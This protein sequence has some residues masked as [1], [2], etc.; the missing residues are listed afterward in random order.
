MARQNGARN[1]E[2][3]AA[4]PSLPDGHYV[5]GLV[6][7]DEAIYADEM[8]H[9]H[10]K[11]WHLACHESELAKAHDFRTMQHAG[12]PLVV[13]RSED[14]QV[15]AF[16]NACSHRG[17]KIVQEPGG[18]AERLTCFYHMWSYDTFGRCIDIPRASGYDAVGLNKADC[19][20]REV[21]T[22]TRWGL[23]FVNLDDD[24]A[25]LDDFLG[26]SLE[27]FESVFDGRELEVFHFHRATVDANWKAWQ[28]TVLDIY[29]EF[30]HVVLR[31]TQMNATPMES[32]KL[33]T[34]P[35]GHGAVIGLKA[36][37]DNYTGWDNR[38]DCRPLPGLTPEDARFAPLFPDLTIILRGT[39]ARI[40]VITPLGPRKTLVEA[41]GLGLKDD[42]PEERLMRIN[43]HNEYW[44]PFG[45]NVTE[46][47][48]AAEACEKTF[49]TGAAHHQII[50]RD[51]GGHG[52]DDGMVR[53]FYAEWNRRM[54]RL[55]SNPT[56]L[57]P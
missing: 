23:V 20:L 38:A 30:M 48:F 47:A 17:A 11:V 1:A 44:G 6:Y 21:R 29:H 49:A 52:Q 16:V 57:V 53:G 12:V 27:I 33:R 41:R 22:A 34:Y 13:I 39:V 15:R 35:G 14:G 28:E 25:P 10:S 9:I 4:A 5:S 55:A 37:Y 54:G 19:G 31:Q 2:A 40:D 24:A 42:T 56:N 32:R 3:W 50:A 51:E 45:R 43:H 8:R 46:D 26:D 36:D 18:N 7:T